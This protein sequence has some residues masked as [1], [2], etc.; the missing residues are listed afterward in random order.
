MGSDKN[1]KEEFSTNKEFCVM[2]K[3]VEMDLAKKKIIFL[4][5]L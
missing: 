2:G 4:Y 5:E 1:K 3:G